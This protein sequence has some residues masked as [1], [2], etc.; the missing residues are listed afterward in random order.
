MYASWK[1]IM[2]IIA[3]LLFPLI[4]KVKEYWI[5]ADLEY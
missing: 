5:D 4:K 3:G 2:V 1:T